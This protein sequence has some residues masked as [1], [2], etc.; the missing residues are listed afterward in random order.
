MKYLLKKL[1][2]FC[3][4]A[5]CAVLFS[6][7]VHA[8]IF[9]GTGFTVA[10]NG[11]RVATSCSTVA[12]SGVAGNRNVRSISLNSF[13]H[14]WLG[15]VEIRVYPPTATI[16]PS[17]AGTTVISSPPDNRACNFAGTYRFIDSATQSVD[18]ATVGCG[19]LTN[20]ASGD[21]RTST[22][23]GGVNPGPVTTLSGSFGSMTPAQVNGNWLVCVFDFAAPD[24]GA[25][26]STSLQ[27]TVLSAAT[28]SVTGRLTTAAGNGIG[29]SI[30][31]LTDAAGNSRTTIT[32]SFGY[33]R[34][35][36]LEAG[37]SYVISAGSKGHAFEPASIVYTAADAAGEVN[38][39]AVP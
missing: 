27:L 7:A 30:V 29:K 21:Y 32:S 39:T 2:V 8:Q 14:T 5:P 36:D 18:A 15:D 10:D 6:G 25:V 3:V 1:R 38:F 16:P 19:D 4:A 13:N 31:T 17:T 33:Y 28:V 12:V 26:G 23:G 34:F 35:D 11:G 9:T 22:Y 24:G 20:L 37:A